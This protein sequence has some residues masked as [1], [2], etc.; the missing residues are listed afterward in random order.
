MSLCSLS[1]LESDLLMK[2][3][4]RCLF[5]FGQRMSISDL[6]SCLRHGMNAQSYKSKHRWSIPNLS[7]LED[8]AEKL[9]FVCE[10]VYTKPKKRPNSNEFYR[11]TSR[12]FYV[13]LPPLHV[14]EALVNA[15]NAIE[16]QSNA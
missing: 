2:D 13:S 1:K 7:E 5:D 16:A 14:C 12:A 11:S 15:M 9:G 10:R 8:V 3:I 6:A 4:A